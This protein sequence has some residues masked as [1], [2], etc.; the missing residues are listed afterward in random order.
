MTTS[1]DDRGK[2]SCQKNQIS[3]TS[4]GK[5][6]RRDSAK[7]RANSLSKSSL[8]LLHNVDD[9]DY[10]DDSTTRTYNYE[11]CRHIDTCNNCHYN[12]V[13]H[14]M[15]ADVSDSQDKG[16]T[17]ECSKFGPVADIGMVDF[18]SGSACQG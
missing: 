11:K 14:G 18:R 17:P 9:D 5:K 10:R 16:V 12:S 7:S 8:F 15:S 1:S 4:S 13:R 3:Q 6:K 2:W